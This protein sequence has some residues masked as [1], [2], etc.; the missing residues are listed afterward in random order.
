MYLVVS[1]TPSY[2]AAKVFINGI[3][4]TLEEAENR[5]LEVCGGLV[6]RTPYGNNSVYGANGLISW[7]KHMKRGDLEKMDIYCPDSL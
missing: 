7:T 6:E 3:Y 5:Q 1:Y 2:S 4:E